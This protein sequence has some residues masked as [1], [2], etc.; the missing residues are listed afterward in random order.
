MDTKVTT[1]S[2]AAVAL[3]GVVAIQM[4][5]VESLQALVDFLNTLIEVLSGMSG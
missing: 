1:L 3:S 2:L 4:G 5:L